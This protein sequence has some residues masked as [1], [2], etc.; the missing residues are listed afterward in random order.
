MK[1]ENNL[2]SVPSESVQISTSITKNATRTRSDGESMY[3]AVLEG[4]WPAAE[5]LLQRAP[6]LAHDELT[7]RGDRAL[8]LAAAMG[9]EKIVRELVERMSSCDLALS[10]GRGCTACCYAAILGEVDIAD[11]MVKNHPNLIIVRDNNNV[12]P[13]HKAALCGNKKM[14]SYFLKSIRVED[15]SREEWFDIVMLVVRT[16]MYD[17]GLEIL[18][19]DGSLATMRNEDGTT[20]HVLAQHDITHFRDDCGILMDSRRVKK[21]AMKGSARDKIEGAMQP[22][23]R[24]LVEKLW[25]EIQRLDR[26]SAR[27]LMKNPPILHDAARVGNVEL[28]TMLTH[29]YP[30]LMWETDSNG[31]T[32]FHVAVIYRRENVFKLI[33][34]TGAMKHFVAT[35]QD[36]NGDNILHLAAKLAPPNRRNIVSIPAFQMQKELA[37]FKEVE[38]IVVAPLCL[39]MRNKDGQ[40]PRELFSKEH[41][42]LLEKSETWMRNTADSC[43]LIATIMLTVVFTAAFTVPGGNDQNTGIPLLLK[44]NWFTCFVIFEALALFGSTLSIILF[45]SIMT[46]SFEENEFMHALPK[47]MKIGLIGL[48]ISL[49]GSIS[50]FMS[51][52]FLAFVSVRG[53]LVKVVIIYGYIFVVLA[54]G[55]EIVKLLLNTNLQRYLSEL[56]PAASQ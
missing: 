15:F 3:E 54:I 20:L 40:T 17:V 10:D 19:K 24:L 16:K 51:A 56:L 13:L 9:H 53:W 34:S 47:Q 49:V 43:M 23:L 27:E 50:A 55:V 30:N 35:S 52:Y 25:T 12:T 28:I 2:H 44:K 18:E 33:H 14:V 1:S 39:E 32:I 42:G 6:T 29:T 26:A 4:D 22:D 7:E 46:S 8:H 11:I 21:A 48:L 37:W 38:A 31:Y 36:Q 5:T 41:K 45:W